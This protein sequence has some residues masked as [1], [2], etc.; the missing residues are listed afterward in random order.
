MPC[1]HALL[2]NMN[3]W[4]DLTFFQSFEMLVYKM[5]PYIRLLNRQLWNHELDKCTLCSKEIGLETFRVIYFYYVATG[6]MPQIGRTTQVVK[7]RQ[8]IVAEGCKDVFSNLLKHKIDLGHVG[9]QMINYTSSTT[10]QIK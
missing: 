5:M 6:H 9:L 8:E 2:Q 1:P 4:M 7:T 10:T 3:N